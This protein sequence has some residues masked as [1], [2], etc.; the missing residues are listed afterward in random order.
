[1]TL[2]APTACLTAHNRPLKA[3]LSPELYVGLGFS[4]RSE[5]G[6]KFVKMIG[7]ISG[8][9]TK[10]FYSSQSN[11]FFLSWRTRVVFTAV[12]SVNEVI[13]IFLQLIL[14]AN[15]AAFFCSLLRLVSHYFWEG[16]EISTARN[17]VASKKSINC[18]IRGL[19]NKRWPANRLFMPIAV[20]STVLSLTNKLSLCLFKPMFWSRCLL[21]WV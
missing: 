3:S 16:E 10:L 4:S 6:L 15:T 20:L 1:V 12:T 8:L 18:E 5:F 17:G 7:P 14:F 13:V 11:D 21:F 9:H 19:F 2:F